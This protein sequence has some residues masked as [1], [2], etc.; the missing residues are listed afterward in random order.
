MHTVAMPE[1]IISQIDAPFMFVTELHS[2]ISA[3]LSWHSPQVPDNCSTEI[4]AVRHSGIGSF[5]RPGSFMN[6]H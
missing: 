6:G 4:L 2:V 1:Y 3:D 5:V